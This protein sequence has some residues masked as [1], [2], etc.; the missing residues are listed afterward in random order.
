VIGVDPFQLPVEAMRAWPSVGVPLIA[1]GAEL[2]GLVAFVAAVAVMPNTPIAAAAT[3]S[4]AGRSRL[5]D[6]R[7]RSPL[8]GKV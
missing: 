1:G 7:M 3:T 5:T 2:V 4:S 6:I 8:D